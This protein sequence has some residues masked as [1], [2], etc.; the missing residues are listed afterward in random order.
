L[1]ALIL[2][3]L[4]AAAIPVQASE[5]RTLLS[6]FGAERLAAEG[7]PPR[8]LAIDQVTGN[9]Y[10]AATRPGNHEGDVVDVF[11]AEGGPP[12]GGVPSQ[13]T[14]AETPGG[15]LGVRSHTLGDIT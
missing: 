10:V 13:I 12:A 9:V 5:L 7:Y 6:T 11:G 3:L 4:L 15:L 14:G 2:T 1:T 8:S